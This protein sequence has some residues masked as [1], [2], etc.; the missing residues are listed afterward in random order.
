M[1]TIALATLA[2]SLISGAAFADAI[3]VGNANQ[4]PVFATNSGDTSDVVDVGTANQAPVF[5]YPS[6]NTSTVIQVGTANRAPVFDDS[7][8]DM[9]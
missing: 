5:D 1:R 6:G 7:R 8:T 3:Q 4:A 9:H 2:F